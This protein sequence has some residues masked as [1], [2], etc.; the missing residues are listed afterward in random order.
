MRRL[1]MKK[2]WWSLLSEY[3]HWD[4]LIHL[5]YTII[6]RVTSYWRRVS[7]GSVVIV[8]LDLEDSSRTKKLWSWPWLHLEKALATKTTGCGLGFE[9]AGIEPIPAVMC[10]AGCITVRILLFCWHYGG[11]VGL[12]MLV[13][14]SCHRRCMRSLVMKMLIMIM[15]RLRSKLRRLL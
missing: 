3:L 1:K 12:L 4:I 11:D 14:R 5:N 15:M 9:N 6:L 10:R 2:W 8:N 13:T 7:P